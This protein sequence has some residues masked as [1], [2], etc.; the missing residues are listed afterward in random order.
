LTFA[1][2]KK[3]ALI[4]C[5]NVWANENLY[6]QDKDKIPY[7]QKKNDSFNLKFCNLVWQAVKSLTI[8]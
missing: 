6:F 2:K 8:E 3:R 5:I 4:L 1:R 7:A